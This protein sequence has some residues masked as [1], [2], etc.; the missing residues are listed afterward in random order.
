[1]KTIFLLLTFFTMSFEGMAQITTHKYAR[2]DSYDRRGRNL[3]DFV[4][5]YDVIDG[6]HTCMNNFMVISNLNYP[7]Y[8]SFSVYFNGNWVYSGTV[9]LKARNTS[10]F[11]NAFTYCNS[12]NATIRIVIDR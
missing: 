6:N 2:I 10:Y 4:F 9:N 7:A 1:M 5:S 3:H 8:F 12:N 11:N